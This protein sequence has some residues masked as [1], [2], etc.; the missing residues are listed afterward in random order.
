M[1]RLL[2]RRALRTILAL[3]VLIQAIFLTDKFTSQ[4]EAVVRNG[5]NALDFAT[6]ML[7]WTPQVVD[8]ALPIVMFLG[9]YLAINGARADN[10]LM[11]CA[12]A[13]ECWNKV[14]RLALIFGSVGLCLSL[15]FSGL[16]TPLS[17]YVLR[18]SFYEMAATQL[19]RQLDTPG[20][21]VQVRRIE[22]RVVIATPPDA[23]E[24]GG[25]FIFASDPTGAAWRVGK[26]VN[27]EVVQTDGPLGYQ[28]RLEGCQEYR[29]SPPTRP[30]AP[31]TELDAPLLPVPPALT[32]GPP[33]LDM[34]RITVS[35]IMLDFHPEDLVRARDETRR[36]GERLLFQSG[37]PLEGVRVLEDGTEVPSPT[38][39]FGEM[40]ARALMSLVAA[41][42]AVAAAGLSATRQGKYLGLPLGLFLV[43]MGDI[44][45]RT[46]L[47]DAAELG[48]LRFWAT[49]LAAAAAGLLPSLAYI[50]WRAEAIVAPTRLS[51]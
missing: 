12:A 43:M 44:G 21:R 1:T 3:F 2:S 19:L 28:L 48:Y 29:S 49:L 9:L 11:I 33:G 42:L 30:D 25:L 50:R 45:S 32:S 5:G 7:L 31:G 46:L 47:G 17:S 41:G 24:R 16:L 6:I 26:A 35:R 38:R 18:L 23:G 27:W 10:E 37:G 4:L 22:D 13:G 15:L 20:E 39:H 40:M 14:P 34:A 36:F 51:T 8:F